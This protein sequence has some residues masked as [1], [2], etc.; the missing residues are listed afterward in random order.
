MSH[1]RN[2]ALAFAGAAL[3]ASLPAA[4]DTSAPAPTPI[5]ITTPGPAPVPLA[6]QPVAPPAAA[7]PPGTYPGYPPGAYPVPYPGAYPAPAYYGPGGYYAPP[8]GYYAARYTPMPLTERQ[9]VG[10]LA[11]GAVAIGAGG[12]MVIAAL[13][14][15]IPTCSFNGNSNADFETCDNHTATV[16]GLTVAGLVAIAVGIPLVVYGNKRIPI[17]AAAATSGL[18]AWAGKP[19]GTGWGWSF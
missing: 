17:G 9:S 7:Y 18:P 12:I 3:F 13:I 5:V 1:A 10:A 4:A 2:L 11:G 6:P 19:G 14:A 15:A 16:V 8:S